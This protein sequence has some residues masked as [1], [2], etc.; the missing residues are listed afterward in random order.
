MAKTDETSSLQRFT[1]YMGPDGDVAWMHPE[2]APDMTAEQAA[3]VAQMR[4]MRDI[5]RGLEAIADAIA[6]HTR[7][8]AK[9]HGV[10][11]D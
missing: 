2:L 5:A 6:E 3:V 4:G 1:F 9:A 11:E 7:V 8:V 10:T